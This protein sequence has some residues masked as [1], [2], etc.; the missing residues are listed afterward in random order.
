MSEILEMTHAHLQ[1]RIA[2]G[3]DAEKGNMRSMTHAVWL[4][5]SVVSKLPSKRQ[6]FGH[7]S[8]EV[9][10]DGKAVFADKSDQQSIASTGAGFVRPSDCT[11]AS[12]KQ[13]GTVD[14]MKKGPL[15]AEL[16]V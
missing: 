5:K 8:S 4:L 16:G 6:M 10:K 9:L 14:S 7:E 2:A 1:L 11:S 13:P 12:R 15:G 3:P